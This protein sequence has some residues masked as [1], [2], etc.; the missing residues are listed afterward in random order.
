[1]SLL[2]RACA[3]VIVCAL[4]GCGSSATEAT[5]TTQ[6]AH[7]ASVGTPSESGAQKSS[8][9]LT[10]EQVSRALGAQVTQF[11]GPPTQES[12]CTFGTAIN[13]GLDPTKPALTLI[14]FPQPERAQTLDA[15]R[16]ELL[17]LGEHGIVA[18]PEWGSGAFVD[19]EEIAQRQ[20]DVFVGPR[21]AL[22]VYPKT[23]SA[24]LTMVAENLGRLLA[25][26]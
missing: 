17:G 26:G 15:L 18:H 10:A 16:K 25:E 21:H 11:P 6:T 22:V 24:D 8:C 1:M 14:P 20:I 4:G 12:I 2:R 7:R 9:P 13:G 5:T 3:L 23:S 19:I